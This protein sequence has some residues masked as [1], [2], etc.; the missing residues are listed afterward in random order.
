[1]PFPEVSRASP[2]AGSSVSEPS[3]Y[4]HDFTG[5]EGVNIYTID[6]DIDIHHAQIE[7][8]LPGT[9][10]LLRMTSTRTA[11]VAGPVAKAVS[12]TPSRS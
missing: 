9:R 4:E 8:A 3:T 10:P 11:T 6:T 1:M 5:G 12:L 2:T 7:V